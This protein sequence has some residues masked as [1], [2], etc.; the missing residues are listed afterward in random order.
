M[1]PQGDPKIPEDVL[2]QLQKPDELK[3]F[4]D[5][6]RSLQ[7][8]IGY[9]DELMEELYQA[10]CEVFAEGKYSESQDGFLFLTTLNPYVYAYWLGLGM[11]H[12]LLEEYEQAILTY[13]CASQV[14]SEA[15]L[16]YYYLAGCHLLLNHLD[17]AKKA[18]ELAKIKCRDKLEHKE[19]LEKVHKAELK[20]GQ[21]YS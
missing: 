3:Q 10:A 14:D 7:E 15:P 8:I 19:L 12:Q 5:D 9:S 21:R 16:P 1:E 17:E 4:I 6:G 13:E 20:I 18:I 2:H 11:S